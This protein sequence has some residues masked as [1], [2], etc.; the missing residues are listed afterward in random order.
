VLAD[1]PALGFKTVNRLEASPV[2]EAKLLA[3]LS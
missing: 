2:G 1:Y 3:K